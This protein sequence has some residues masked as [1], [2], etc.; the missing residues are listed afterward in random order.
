MGPRFTLSS[1]R[2][3]EKIELAS[4]GVE[5]TTCSDMRHCVHESYAP[6][7]EPIGRFQVLVKQRN[8]IN[9]NVIAVNFF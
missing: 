6:P 1:E 3:L 8:G 4:Q 9:H 5:P 2:L 7:T